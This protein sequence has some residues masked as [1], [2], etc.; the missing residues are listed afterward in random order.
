MVRIAGVHAIEA[1]VQS[2]PNATCPLH[3]IP[4]HL[5]IMDRRFVASK[6]MHMNAGVNTIITVPCCTGFFGRTPTF[7]LLM[8]P[9]FFWH[10]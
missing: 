10:A 7:R 1:G 4:D 2:N 6:G 3:G 9:R 8:P 5:Q